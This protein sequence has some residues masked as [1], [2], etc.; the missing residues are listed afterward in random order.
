MNLNNISRSSRFL[1]TILCLSVCMLTTPVHAA[2]RDASA[3]VITSTTLPFDNSLR[4]IGRHMTIQDKNRPITYGYSI[5]G[6][7]SLTGLDLSMLMRMSLAR[8]AAASQ[9]AIQISTMGMGPANSS[10][11]GVS[12]EFYLRQSRSDALEQLVLPDFVISGGIS[13]ISPDA[14]LQDRGLRASGPR[15]SLDLSKSASTTTID[16]V[17]FVQ[18]F[19]GIDQGEPT[20]VRIKFQ[21]IQRRAEIGFRWGQDHVIGLS[22]AAT[23]D[24]G[25]A[26]SPITQGLQ[27]A[28]VLLI[29][30][31]FEIKPD[32]CRLALIRQ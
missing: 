16:L 20:T 15:F 25:D 17:L 32:Q 4:C 11:R 5:A 23:R 31:H 24:E 14:G 28:T 30:S 21:N 9:G 8:I 22:W 26:Y 1:T 18:D 29:A 3:V 10:E 19:N 12:N 27:W 2:T 6:A 13:G 7:W